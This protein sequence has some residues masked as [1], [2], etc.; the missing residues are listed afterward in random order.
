MKRTLCHIAARLTV[1]IIGS[2]VFALGGCTTS[3]GE[4]FAIY[5]TKIDVSPAQMPAL[6][7][8]DIADHPIVATSDIVTYDAKTHEIALT[9]GAYERISSLTVPVTGKSF[10][11]CVDGN[12]IYGGAFWTLFSSAS[13]DGVIIMKPLS[14]QDTKPQDA[15]VVKLELGYPSLSFYRGEDPR[16]DAQVMKSLEQAGTLK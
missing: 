16:T 3:K 8:V 10:V 1:L 6:S 9:K 11:V 7:Y 2:A 12:P 13:F 4:G 5:L 15:N 14:L